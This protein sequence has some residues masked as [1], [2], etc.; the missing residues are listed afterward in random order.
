MQIWSILNTKKAKKPQAKILTRK[1]PF[2]IQDLIQ[3]EI[4][5]MEDLE[6]EMRGEIDKRR[7]RFVRPE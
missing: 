5:E 1:K 7:G 3:R 6:S 4:M 2:S